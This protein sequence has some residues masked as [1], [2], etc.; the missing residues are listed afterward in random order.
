MVGKKWGSVGGRLVGELSAA[1]R[2]E[3]GAGEGDS[4]GAQGDEGLLPVGSG[5]DWGRRERFDPKPVDTREETCTW[6]PGP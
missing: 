4:M 6:L 5:L 3:C 1:H 2:E